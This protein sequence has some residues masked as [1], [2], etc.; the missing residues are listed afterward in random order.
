MLKTTLLM[1]VT[2]DGKIAKSDDHF[3]DWTGSADKKLFAKISKE[4]GVV[5]M[6][7]KTFDTFGKP[8]PGRKNVVMT[9]NASRVSS[10]EN[11]MYTD[12]APRVIVEDLAKEGFSHAIL[13]GG[14]TINT[15]FARA[16][17]IDEIMI[18]I[19]PTIF[20]AGI[21]L[22]S[23]SVDMDL[24]LKTVETVGEGLVSVTYS[25]KKTGL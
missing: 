16:G 10:W 8:L 2:A 9:R 12:R 20:G 11:L 17:L 19:C 7:S 6:G 22:F 24:D 5:I 18:T 4:A 25:V 1:A 21:S 23:D 13:A 3:P 15:L 14:A